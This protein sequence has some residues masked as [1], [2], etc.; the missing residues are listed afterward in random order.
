MSS[1]QLKKR[2]DELTE[3][4]WNISNDGLTALKH[5]A[6]K[7]DL[8]PLAPCTIVVAG[9][10]GKGS[11]IATLESIY[12]QRC[13]SC[14]TLPVKTNHAKCELIHEQQGKQAANEQFEKRVREVGY[15]VATFTSPH[16]FSFNERLRFNK[17]EVSDPDILS[18]FAVID[19]I[20]P[21]K[22][23]SYFEYTTLALFYL[24]KNAQVDIA[25]LEVGMGG[26][27]D[28]V[29]IVDADITVITSIALDHCHYL[30]DTR[31]AIARE[32]AGIM[33]SHR[34]CICG[35]QDP[36]SSLIDMAYAQQTP[37]YRIKQ[38]F[39]LYP[40]GYH[41][42]FATKENMWPNL[43]QTT[44]MNSNVATALMVVKQL[45]KRYP[46]SLSAIQHGL[47]NIELTAR[48]QII[49]GPVTSLFDVAH[50]PAAI[51]ALSDRIPPLLSFYSDENI[52]SK[53]IGKR[54]GLIGMLADKPLKDALEAI[55]PKIDEWHVIDLSVSVARGA[56]ADQLAIALETLG[57][58]P[59]HRHKKASDTY[60]TLKQ[61]A[62]PGDWIICFGSFYL[63]N[64]LE[65]FIPKSA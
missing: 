27:L 22:T 55:Y 44:L 39:D 56:M 13:S 42:L 52:E 21:E 25:L 23:L 34:P 49:K 1:E 9:T 16:L 38:D 65:Q 26:R 2:L 20:H 24:I 59:V 51:L 62:E 53:T 14:R 30:G 15:S 41:N 3:H 63:L 17:K 50:N 8:L 6:K 43:P 64:Q 12:T 45:S 46:V 61:Q 31:E 40:T 28:A 7:L 60:D 57:E 11:C 37:L 4:P 19:A 29:N 5:I 58:T 18:A 36:P 10:N 54:Y 48:Q 35:D 32:K 47:R 33:R